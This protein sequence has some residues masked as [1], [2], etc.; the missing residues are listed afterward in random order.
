MPLKSASIQSFFSS[1]PPKPATPSTTTTT[2]HSSSTIPPSSSPTPGDG[3]T[4]AEIAATLGP[5]AA[6][7]VP[8]V[9]SEAYQH[10]AIAALREGQRCVEVK[11]RVASLW[12]LQREPKGPRAA[13]GR[14]G[15]VVR[16]DTGWLTVRLW[17]AQHLPS[18]T[19][20]AL[21]TV[22]TPHIGMAHESARGAPLA[23]V[24]APLFASIFPERDRM[25]HIV[26]HEGEEDD[27]RFKAPLGMVEGKQLDCLMTLGTFIN[28]GCEVLHAR[29]LVCVKSVGARKKVTTKDG[30]EVDKVEV[31]VFDNT[32]E[33]TL[34]L[35]AATTTSAAQ[36]KPSHTVLL[37][38]SPAYRIRGSRAYLSFKSESHTDVDPVMPDAEW[39]RGYAQRLTKKQ[40]VN[41]PFPKNIF[42]PQ[43]LENAPLRMLFT[44]AD[45]D[46]FARAAPRQK[47]TGYL[48]VIITELN[49]LSLHRRN[50]L[51][52]TECCGIPLHANAPTAPC[53][54]C[55]KPASL[56]L[57]PRI[58]G[59]VVDETGS[60]A[61]GKLILSTRAWEELLG[62]SAEQFLGESLDVLRYLEQR[63]LFGRVTMM[64]GWTGVEYEWGEKQ[65]K[66]KGVESNDQ[67]G[68]G[69]LCVFGV[70]G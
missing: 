67:G 51:A 19:L 68:E 49:I 34:T 59:P 9:P 55:D 26:V 38:T 13:R 39:L 10:S 52:C 33:G 15:F 41:P 17:Y 43:E 23:P 54:Q 45:I 4:A 70:R 5:Q 28:G 44:L 1:S 8:W 57:N 14:L 47:V 24:S 30:S 18:I 7:A 42:D 35:W 50:M 66:G 53:K 64:V 65:K 25:C 12:L 37:L 63:L 62:R 48:S 29:I 3:F 20:G 46:D 6:P 58:L 31:H 2:L 16:D 61:T 69:R 27:G 21:V 32:A 11:G 36:W 22:Y 60:I 40:H 56:S